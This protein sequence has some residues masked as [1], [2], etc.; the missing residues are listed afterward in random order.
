[1]VWDM[2]YGYLHGGEKAELYFLQYPSV[3]D[4]WFAPRSMSFCAL[5]VCPAQPEKAPRQRI[6]GDCSRTP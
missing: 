6:K 5:L 4:R 3:T 1:M 2:P